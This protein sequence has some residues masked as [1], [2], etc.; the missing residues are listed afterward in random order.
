MRGYAPIKLQTVEHAKRRECPWLQ[1]EGRM[2]PCRAFHCMAWQPCDDG[3]AVETAPGY[4]LRM[5][6]ED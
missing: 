2:L 1:R 3:G 5:H 6:K 4:C